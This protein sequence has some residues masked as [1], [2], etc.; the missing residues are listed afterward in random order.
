MGESMRP[1]EGSGLQQEPAL[2][3]L[4]PRPWLPE[5]QVVITVDLNED[6]C[7]TTVETDDNPRMPD[8]L[9]GMYY[10]G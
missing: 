9:H 3:L 10:L 4:R 8:A 2:A 6:P 1:I 5:D 7:D